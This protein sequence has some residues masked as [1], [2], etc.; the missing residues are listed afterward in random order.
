MLNKFDYFKPNNLKEVF[1]IFDN[2]EGEAA[3]LAGGTDLFVDMKHKTRKPD[4]VI[5][6]KSI[7]DFSK[8]E[9]RDEG[10]FIGGTVTCNEIIDS[11][12]VNDNY[13]VL[14]DAALEVAA[15]Q[16][17]NR[18]TVVGNLCTTSPGADMFP[19]LLVL[20]TTVLVESK[21]GSREIPL[22]E[23]ATGVKQNALSD[24]EVVKGI[25]VQKHADDGKGAYLKKRRTKGPDLSGVGVAGYLSEEEEYLAFALGAVAPTPV[26]V[27]VSEIFFADGSFEDKQAKIVER[28]LDNINPIDDVR[29]TKAYRNKLSEV[30][31]KRILSRLWESGDK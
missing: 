29:S 10:L 28:V 9:E 26:Y 4:Y 3:L 1:E 30:Y 21:E 25:L 31:T 23:F 12:L 20:N 18:A 13:K 11:E 5:D 24:K 22:K 17:R 27:N 19:P 16:V 2:N 6:V 8:I 15:H 14:A 7:E